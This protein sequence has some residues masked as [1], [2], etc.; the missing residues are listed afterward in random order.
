MRLIICLK[1]LQVGKIARCFEPALILL[2]HKVELD[3]RSAI[4]VSDEEFLVDD[5]L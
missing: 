5:D 3:K 1:K 2:L 4:A